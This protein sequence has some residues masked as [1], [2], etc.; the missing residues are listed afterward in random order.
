MNK[1]V[2]IGLLSC[3]GCIGIF[4]LLMVIGTVGSIFFPIK[5]APIL[6]KH[7]G[8][9]I[10]LTK[11]HSVHNGRTTGGYKGPDYVAMLGMPKRNVMNALPASILGCSAGERPG[12]EECSFGADDV[13]SF[14]RG[15]AVSFSI[16][17]A[18]NEQTIAA[19]LA[20]IG[21]DIAQ[22]PAGDKTR[23]INDNVVNEKWSGSLLGCPHLN[24]LVAPQDVHAPGD[25]PYRYGF[26]QMSTEDNYP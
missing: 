24:L 3:G 20:D 26:I 25:N 8:H 13:V 17:L 19:A 21:I 2:K 7:S 14:R 5:D 1:P 9:A 16:F 10:K 12:Y 6:Q 15:K 11:R 18:N 23:D 4:M 22:L